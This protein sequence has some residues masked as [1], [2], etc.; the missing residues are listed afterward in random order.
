MEINKV[1]LK[2]S[3]EG[4]E[5]FAKLDQLNQKYA[6]STEELRKTEAE[7]QRLID[8]EAK[9]M[10]ARKN[11]NNPTAVVRYNKELENTRK[12]IEVTEKSVKS[13][14]VETRKYGRELE[15]VTAKTKKA[16]DA[17]V[18]QAQTKALT[19]SGGGIAGLLSVA[20]GLGI[21]TGIG[22]IVSGLKS[23]TF[24]AVE[25]SA[26][27]EGIQTA[28]SRIGGE[29]TLEKLRIATRGATSDLVLMQAAL[30]AKNFG[31]APELL[32]KGLQLAGQV[33]RTTGQD[34]DYLTDSFVN[35][36]GR[37]SLLILDNLQISQVA[38]RAEIKKTGDFNTAVGN[39]IDAKL[40]E[41]GIVIDTT[42]DKLAHFNATWENFKKSA[43][44][45]LVNAGAGII[46]FFKALGTSVTFADVQTKKALEIANGAIQDFNGKTLDQAKES[47]VER[48]RL[49]AE[50]S[51]R[52]VDL[53]H[54]L[55]RSTTKIDKEALLEK[56]KNASGFEKI[57]IAK[58]LEEV[59][60]LEKRT[61]L[62]FQL[63]QLG[64]QNE[65]KLNDD[66]RNLNK[67]RTEVV[68]EEGAKRLRKERKFLE[69]LE[70]DIRRAQSSLRQSRGDNALLS[71][72]DEVSKI[73]VRFAELSIQKNIEFEKRKKAIEEEIQSESIKTEALINLKH[74]ENI[75]L[76][77]LDEERIASIRDF[78]L[79]QASIQIEG[80]KSV[81]ELELKTAQALT[82][83]TLED[84]D[85]RIAIIVDS[86]AKKVELM[87]KEG[88]DEIEILKFIKEQALAVEEIRKSQLLK[89]QAQFNAEFE[90][91]ERN[92]LANLEYKKRI[93]QSQITTSEIKFEEEQLKLLKKQYDEQVAITGEQDQAKLLEI[94]KQE[95]NIALLKKKQ[96]KEERQEI[97][98]QTIFII[99]NINL[100]TQAVIDGVDQ[101]ISA[102]IR[103]TDALIS[104]QEKR[105][106]EV[107]KIAENGNAK[108]LELEKD[109]L[110]KLNKEKEKFVRQQQTLAS[111][112]LVANTAV[113]VSKAA[114]EGGAGAAFTIAAALIALVAG[115][116]S[117]RS[118]AG[119]AA[120]YEGGL[121]S[122]EGGYTGNGN[123]RSIST[124]LGG[125]P[126]DYHKEEF[127]HNHQTTRK[128]RPIFEDVHRGKI[129]LN[130]MKSKA[131]LYD[132]LKMN[133]I[134][135]SREIYL[136]SP[137]SGNSRELGSIKKTLDSVVNAIKDQPGMSL[138]IDENGIAF[139]THRFYKNKQRIDSIT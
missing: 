91:V 17:S 98:D 125:K 21:A 71:E 135:T 47:E 128:F 124:A 75:E 61:K 110:E 37:K 74:L 84:S 106:N 1:I 24:E 40:K 16:F 22:A 65:K 6:K 133:N 103:E 18:V 62:E 23:A 55:G 112:E 121:Y 122:E 59:D 115:L 34:V 102:K 95:N 56:H 58:Q 48:T 43:G 28:F 29:A 123:P 87:Q 111:I 78:K 127:I 3:S 70:I 129:D 139:I 114:A 12:S 66:L 33:A 138:H 136:K 130:E 90:E 20:G 85:E 57:R 25:L 39:I 30:R 36:L 101:V 51:A 107:E 42:A 117:A 80:A 119:Q 63:N 89:V 41:T 113:A 4:D 88:K 97:I 26:K 105:V 120:F 79:R 54:A 96:R 94:Q 35:G 10:E 77:E 118:I 100:V 50:S 132:I 104:L 7:L 86:T 19:G 67:K 134:D 131:E 82:T 99:D 14:T 38:L 32:A 69:D 81:A 53:T 13:L 68:D 15:T 64:L 27:A 31:I 137:E 76:N 9:L 44:D 11:A 72:L 5:V 92:H 45:F 60:A 126:Y 8:K 83:F 116:A 49:L 52:I 108:L 73:N 46:D 2:L 93:H 109:R